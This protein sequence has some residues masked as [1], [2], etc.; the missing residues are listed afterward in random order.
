MFQDFN[1]L[2]Q[3]KKYSYNTRKSYIG[4]LQV[5]QDFLGF[6]MPM[7]RLEEYYL[8]QK[9]GELILTKSYAYTTQKQLLSAVRLYLLE[10]HKRDVDFKKL[11]PRTPQGVLPNILSLQEVTLLLNRTKNKK[12][13]AMLATVYSLGLRSG[14]LIQLKLADLDKHRNC[15]FIR[16]S[17]GRKDRIVPYPDSLKTILRTYYKEYKPVN[18]LFEGQKKETYTTASLRAVFN[19]ACKRAGITKDVTCHNLRHS[20]ATHLL[21]AGTNLKVIQNLLGHNNIKTTLLYTRV[22]DRNIA[23]A[24]SPLDFLKLEETLK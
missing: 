13:K 21:E 22:S 24:S 14:E 17:K 5:F 1:T 23:N 4:L 16:Q 2:L 12:H 10:M 7:D 11:Q 8:F 19:A 20:Y 9:L 6:Q 18:Y 15:V 3:I